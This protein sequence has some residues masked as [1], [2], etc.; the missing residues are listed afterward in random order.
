MLNKTYFFI[1]LLVAGVLTQG[2]A[3]VQW[4]TPAILHANPYN[5]LYVG[6][7]APTGYDNSGDII[8]Y[9]LEIDG[10]DVYDGFSSAVRA[11]TTST[12]PSV[13]GSTE[14][15]LSLSASFNAAGNLTGVRGYAT[16]SVMDI[17]VSGRTSVAL[18]GNF[19][20]DLTTATGNLF[21]NT[22]L[23]KYYVAG[24]WSVLT[25]TSANVASPD[26]ILTAVMGTDLLNN[27]SSWGAYIEGRGYFQNKVSIGTQNMPA[28]V[29]SNN[30]A[31]Y[32]LF[33]KGGI[34]SDEVLVRT[35]WA[36]YVF[37]PS[38]QLKP[39]HEVEQAIQAEGKLPNMPS[40]KTV[41]ESGLNLGEAARLQQ[42]KIEE[43]FL[44]VI[45][46]NKDMEALKAENQALKQ[47]LNALNAQTNDK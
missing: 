23:G 33:V 15:F 7:F 38:Y 41:E 43:L 10:R 16:P 44:Y 2:L 42:E 13:V 32:N 37:L 26:A 35:G 34:L 8:S 27:G 14:S 29:G 46:L 31:N 5:S 45:Q 21:G 39:L 25:G 47:Q 36:D 4:L 1:C 24:S 40:A 22:G 11:H 19:V 6:P 28:M 17:T 18:G 30:T 9:E 20:A 12:G 3:Q